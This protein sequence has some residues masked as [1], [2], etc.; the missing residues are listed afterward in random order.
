MS[1]SVTPEVMHV[2]QQA[3]GSTP[4]VQVSNEH[5]PSP[6]PIYGRTWESDMEILLK[7]GLR[8]TIANLCF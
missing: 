5:R 8:C 4:S 6:N 7:V 1:L 3:N 2:T